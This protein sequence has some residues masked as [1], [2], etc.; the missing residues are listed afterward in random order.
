MPELRDEK[1]D[2]LEQYL[3]G[4]LWLTKDAKRREGWAFH[5]PDE[6]ILHHGALAAAGPYTD[7]ERDAI[8]AA[9]DN[10]REPPAIKMCFRNATLLAEAARVAGVDLDYAEGKVAVMIPIDHAWC[11]L[12]SGKPVDITLRTTA[13]Y[14]AIDDAVGGDFAALEDFDDGDVD[15]DALLARAEHNLAENAYWGYAVPFRERWDH[16][17]RVGRWTMV[18]EDPEGDFPLIRCREL[19][20]R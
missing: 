1:V 20:W 19:P 12:P 5:S 13:E 7:D 11:A 8:R 10:L 16:L 6:A 14:R 3:R 15:P 2:G 18:L 17:E 9:L 4:M